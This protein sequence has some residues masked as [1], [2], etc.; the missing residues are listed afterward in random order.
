M[1]RQSCEQPNCNEPAVSFV[2]SAV[3]SQ[4]LCENHAPADVAVT[5]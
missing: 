5:R 1:S 4:F 2:E 3:A